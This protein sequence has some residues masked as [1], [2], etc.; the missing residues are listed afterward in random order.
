M[1]DHHPF[2]R[3]LW[4]DFFS[5]DS[6]LFSPPLKSCI[7]TLETSSPTKAQKI[8]SRSRW[9][10]IAA[11]HHRSNRI[12]EIAKDPDLLVHSSIC[13]LNPLGTQLPLLA[14]LFFLLLAPSSHPGCFRPSLRLQRHRL[15]HP[16]TFSFLFSLNSR[17][18]VIPSFM[19]AQWR[20]HLLS[21]QAFRRLFFPLF[22]R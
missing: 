15:E 21:F 3:L 7:F 13:T 11:E 8:P 12:A 17:K 1:A 20:I 9:P 4:N 22:F 16:P 2:L 6:P 18:V 14:A 19:T 5:S 10:R